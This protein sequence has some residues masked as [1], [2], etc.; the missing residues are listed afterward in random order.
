MLLLML[1]YLE[2][3]LDSESWW[4]NNILSWF[5][6]QLVLTSGATNLNSVTLTNERRNY[7]KEAKVKYPHGYGNNTMGEHWREIY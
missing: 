2:T 4:L 1:P 6:G 7:N 3:V 5:V